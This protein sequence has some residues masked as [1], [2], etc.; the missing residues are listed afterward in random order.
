M[1][2]ETAPEALSPVIAIAL[3]GG[4]GVGSQWLAWRLR[5]PAIVLMLVAGVLIGPVLGVFDPARDF[6][7]LM[8][9]IIAIAVAIIL[10]EGGLTLNFHQL[11]DAA[12][13]VQRL[14]FI[15]APVGW[16]LSALALKYGAGLSWSS[17]WVFGGILIVTG[18]TVI[19][20]LLRTARLSRRPGQLLQWEAIVNDPLGA[21][22][23]VLAFEVVLV[24]NTATTTGAAVL[25]L[26]LGIGLAVAFGLAGGYGI[27]WAF[28]NGHVP[29]YMKVSVLFALLLGIFGLSDAVLHESGLLAVT[30]MGIVIANANL[31]SY[32]EL[33]RFKEHATILLVSGVFILLAANL[34]FS[35]LGQLT[36]RAAIFVALII[37]VARPVTVFVSL[38]GSGLPWR[39]QVLVAFTGP[40]GV[41][42]VAVAGL[43]AERLMS[44]GF[45]DAELI[46][47]LAFV[48]VATTVV[49]HG[50]TLKP[51]ARWLGLAGAGNPGVIIVGGSDWTT[52][53][54]EALIKAD[55]PVLMT[56][57]N[58]GHL[59]AARAA[60]IQ[61]YTGD[62]LSEGA[63]Q[64]LELVSY[65]KMLTATDNDAYN[66]LVATDLAPEFGRENVFQVERVK[67][68]GARHT[69]PATLGGRPIGHRATYDEWNRLVRQGWTFRITRLTA[70]F[71]L[72]DWQEKRPRSHL[73]GRILPNGDF[74]L[75]Q[76]DEE[77]RGLP[78][79]RLI[80]LRP[81]E[82][83]GSTIQPPADT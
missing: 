47:P 6:G 20:P 14:V 35:E 17:S 71:T 68:D 60:G 51:M 29:E 58:F 76:E 5:M 34:D 66:T 44:L 9:P 15:G 53:L 45:E 32:E 18:P 75:L 50:F 7:P 54:A 2:I 77:I 22:A 26:M 46:G 67:T 36:G 43:F 10:F 8:A 13:G 19:A 82:S 78:D 56:D 41:V 24:L 42:L 55:V 48:L 3:V 80:A 30:V 38:I 12:V 31:P 79:T 73:V 74:K 27:A 63:E 16:V 64:R 4:L 40:R 33:R 52:A 23:A 57:P 69:L 25:D 72:K 70:E 49:L 11:R 65:D 28:R 59:R 83:N 37:F 1:A 81:P 62:I 39:E 21:L 61:T